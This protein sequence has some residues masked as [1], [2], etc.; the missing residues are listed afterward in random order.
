MA[1]KPAKTLYAGLRT[2]LLEFVHD[3]Q[4]AYGT[5]R[6]SM[7]DAKKVD[8]PDLLAT[9]RHAR[10]A[11]KVAYQPEFYVLLVQGDIEPSLQGPYATQDEQQKA[12]RA[13]KTQYG[14]HAG[15]YWLELD[16]GVPKA[17]AYSRAFFES[18]E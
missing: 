15:I 2:V 3:V 17:G 14:D 16:S 18:G 9:Y 7:L 1:K 6:N 12:A 11:L 13:L 8:W 10:Q 4:A 5:G